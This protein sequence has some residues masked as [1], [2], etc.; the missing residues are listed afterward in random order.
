MILLQIFSLPNLAREKRK[1]KKTEPR[2]RG[3]GKAE[4]FVC[5]CLKYAGSEAMAALGTPLCD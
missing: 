2:D 4:P 5:Q 3:Q 1:K